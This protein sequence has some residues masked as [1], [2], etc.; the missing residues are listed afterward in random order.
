MV[1]A[2]GDVNP[3]SFR[4]NPDIPGAPELPFFGPEPA[5]FAEERTGGREVLDTVVSHIGYVNVAVRGY[6]DASKVIELPVTRTGRTPFPEERTRRSKI[7]EP[8]VGHIP[9]VRCVNVT[10]GGYGY[11]RYTHELARAESPPAPFAEERA[12][13]GEVLNTVVPSIGYVNGPVRC[14]VYVPRV[15]ELAVAGAPRAPFPKE[16]TCR[17]EELDTVV[18]I[19]CNVNYTRWSRGDTGSTSEF[20]VTL[21]VRPPLAK[22]RASCGIILYLVLTTPDYIDVAARRYVQEEGVFVRPLSLEGP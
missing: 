16:G 14:Y 10:A 5:P 4:R 12:G 1:L 8:L 6:R 21:T 20:A 9:V 18:P 3:L 17:R 22:E 15:L 19:V 2:V 13:R 7:L 11:T